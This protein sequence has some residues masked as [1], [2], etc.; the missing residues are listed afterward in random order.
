MPFPVANRH[1]VSLTPI[2]PFPVSF[3]RRPTLPHIISS[4]RSSRRGN[5]RRKAMLPFPIEL[6]NEINFRRMIGLS[7]AGLHIS[8]IRGR[9]FRKLAELLGISSNS[10]ISFPISCHNSCSSPNTLRNSMNVLS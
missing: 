10:L 4:P 3:P 5:T 1:R 6:E 9:S 2:R 8:G 7:S